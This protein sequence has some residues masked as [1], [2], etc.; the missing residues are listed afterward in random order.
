MQLHKVIT[1][2]KITGYEIAKRVCI[3]LGRIFAL[4]ELK[5]INYR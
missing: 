1:I 2:A 5:N 4:E 3:K